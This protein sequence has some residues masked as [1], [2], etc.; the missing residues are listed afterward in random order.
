MPQQITLG[1][2]YDHTFQGFLTE[3]LNDV[4]CHYID[5]AKTA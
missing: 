1:K 2:E 4:L 5:A 3:D